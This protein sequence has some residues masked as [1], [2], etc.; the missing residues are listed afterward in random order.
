MVV[1]G[2]HTSEGMRFARLLMSGTTIT[3]SD[4]V[5]ETALFATD[6]RARG[7]KIV[8][9]DNIKLILFRSANAIT[10]I[11]SLDYSNLSLTMR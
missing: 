8:D 2:S 5:Y 7:M 10:Y 3:S 4:F 9:A 6:L 11:S 1:G